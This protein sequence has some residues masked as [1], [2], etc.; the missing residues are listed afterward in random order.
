M[1]TSRNNKEFPLLFQNVNSWWW[2]GGVGW[3]GWMLRS[4]HIWDKVKTPLLG[5]SASLS[6]KFMI[7]QIEVYVLMVRFQILKLIF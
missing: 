1:M 5:T 7:F 2:W 6:S 4:L 3:V